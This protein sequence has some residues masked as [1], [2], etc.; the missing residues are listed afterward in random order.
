MPKKNNGSTSN[1]KNAVT[2]AKER[3]LEVAQRNP[4]ETFL[5][6]IFSD[7]DWS[8]EGWDA[9]KSTKGEKHDRIKKRKRKH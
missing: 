6:D 5:W 7:K 4:P 3:V 2:G 1:N 8:Q 9:R